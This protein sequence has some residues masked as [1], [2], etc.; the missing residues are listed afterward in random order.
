MDSK[1]FDQLFKEKVGEA[2]GLYAEEI[3]ATKPY[4]WTAIQAELYPQKRERKWWF[5][6]AACLLLLLSFGS[7]LFWQID[8]R[9]QERMALLNS[10]LQEMKGEKA[11]QIAALHQKNAEIEAVKIALEELQESLD[12]QQPVST[13]LPRYIVQK[14]TLVVERI[15][16]VEQPVPVEEITT[17]TA[18]EKAEEEKTPNY[19]THV[20]IYP[21]SKAQRRQ[22]NNFNS[23]GLRL[24]Q[25]SKQ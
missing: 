12:A 20:A 13:P 15:Q 24:A 5:L 21:R 6:A 2:N 17:L 16:Y 19:D 4:A 18:A 11:V 1:A 23:R 7:F 8:E 25:L 14:D 3:Q 22:Q 10:Q 9:H